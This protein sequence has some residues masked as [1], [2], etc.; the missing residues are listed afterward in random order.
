MSLPKGG[1]AIKGIGEKFAAHPVTGAGA[2]TVPV[3]ATPGRSGFGPDPVLRYGSGEGNGP[4]GL[5]WSLGLPAI[6]RRTDKGVPRYDDASDSDVFILSGAEDLVPVLVREGDGWVPEALP[7][8]AIGGARYTV[9]R[10]RPRSEGLFARIE[11]WTNTGDPADVFWRSISRDD[12]TTWYGCTPES[13][14]TDPADASRVFAWLICESHDDRGNLIAYGYKAEDD[15]GVDTAAGHERNRQRTANRHL[16]RIRY[17]NRTPWP[18]SLDAAT[19]RRPLPGDGQWHFELVLDY[20]EHDRAAPTPHGAGAWSAR[21]DAFSTFRPGFEVRT[22]RLCRRVLMFHHFPD[23][24]EVGADALVRSTELG[25][26][27]G[28]HATLTAVTHRGHQRDGGGHRTRALPPV[29]FE[30]SRPVVYHTVRELDEESLDG[31]PTGLDGTRHQ[32]VDLDGEGLP[33][34]L[35]EQGGGWFHKRNLSPLTPAR[36][37][38]GPVEAVPS[39]PSPALATGARFLDLAGDGSPDLVRFTGPDPGFQERAADGT[40]EPY[41]PFVS[42]PDRD[43]ADPNLR[44]VDLDGDGLADVLVTEDDALVWHPSL[45][46]D[47]FG[48]ERREVRARDEERGPRLVFADAEQSVVLADMTGDGLTDLVRIRNGE[49]C[50]WPNLGH[51]RFGPKI[52]MAGAP[53]DHPDR[54]D[55]RRVLL[56]D[57][58][59]SGTTDLVHLHA[60]GARIHFNRSGNDF[61]PPVALPTLPPADSIT[62]VLALDLLGNGTACLVWSSPLPADGR[63]PLRYLDLMGGVKPHLLTR[64]RNNLGA[65]TEIGYAPSTA[66]C[67]RDRRAG[68]PWETKLPFPVHVVERTTVRDKWRGT[69]FTSRHSYHHGCFDGAEREFRGFARVERTDVEDY[70]TFTAAN[71]DS[72]YV[73]ADHRLHQPPV[74]TVTWH[75]TGVPVA[76]RDPQ[77][78]FRHEYFRASEEY[79]PPGPGLDALPLGPGERREAVRAFHGALLREETYEL[80]LGAATDGE[81]PAVPVRVL[82]ATTHAPHIRLVQP[83]AGRQHAVFHTFEGESVAHHYELDLRTP[84]STPPAAPDPRIV[85]TLNLTVDP[86]GNVLQSVTVGYPRTRPS[87]LADPLLPPG[88]DTLVASVQGELRA[89]YTEI[90]TTDPLPPDPD[91]YRLPLPCETRTHELTGTGPD[92]AGDGRWVTAE[93]MLRFRLGER[94]QTGGTPVAELEH[95]RLPDGT[96]P[97]KRLLGLVRTLYYDETL[98]APLPLGGLTA[99]A[100]PYGTYALARTDAL[101]TAVLGDRATPEVRA[102]AADRT[103]SGHLGGQAAVRLLGEDA[104]GRYWRCSEGAEYDPDAPQR[105]FLPAR[106]TDAFGSTTLLE[107]DPYGLSLKAS[108]DPLGNRSEVLA[109]DY[110]VMAPRRTRDVNGNQAEVLFDALGLPAAAARSGKDGAGDHR[111]GHDTAALNPQAARRHGLVLTDDHDPVRARAL[112]LG[113]GNRWLFHFG[114]ELRDGEVVWAL[115]PPC[116]A[117][118][119][120]ER[121]ADEQPESP[122]QAAFLYAD[123]LGNTLVKKVQAEPEEPGGPLRWV[124][125]G[126]TVVNNKGNPVK[127]YEPYFSPPGSGHRFEEPGEQGVTP[128]HFYDAIGRLIRTDLPD[129]SHHRVE[130]SPWHVTDHDANDTVLEPGNGWY[131]RMSTSALP[132]ERRAARQ[133]AAHAGTPGCALLDSRGHTVVTI[134]HNRDDGVDEKHV[135]FTRRDVEGT[136]LWIQ[137]PRG[138]RVLQH[139]VPPLPPGV[140]PLDDPQNLFPHGFSP[141]YDL[142]GHALFEH[143]PDA[144]DRLTLRDAADGLLFSWNGRGFRTRT[145][146]DALRRPVG[147]YVT[148]A[149]DTNLS[150]APRDPGAPPDPEVLVEYRVHGEAHPEPDR[151]LRGRTFRV[152]DGCGVTT[153]ERYDFQGNLLATSRR[154]ARDHTGTPDWSALASLT[155]PDLIAG[156]AEALL[157]PGPALTTSTAYDA[158]DRPVATTAPDGSETRWA[159]NEAGLPERVEVRLRG[160]A[161]PTAFVT[162]VDYDA[163][164]RRT[165]VVHGNGARTA[166]TYDPATFR[167][168]GVRTTRPAGPDTTAS[169]LFANASVVQDLH[170]TH[171]PVGNVTRVEDASLATI[172]GAATARDFTHDALYRLVAA[173]GREH[174][175]QTAF[176]PDPPDAGRRDHP[177]AGA[178]VHPNDLQGLRGYVER[179]RYDAVG[180]LMHVAH[181]EGADVEAPGPVLWRR[182]HQYALDG[183]RLLATSLPGETGGLPDYAADGGYGARYGHDVHGNMTRMPHLPLMRWDHGDRLAATARQVVNDGTPETTYYVHDSAGE[184]VRKVT[185]TMGGAVKNERRYLGGFE[186]Y[187]EYG[188]G[189]TTLERETLHIGDAG[190]QIALVET[191]VLPAGRPAVRYRFT[192]HQESVCVEL[193][194]NGALVGHE[195]YHPYGTTAFQAGRTAAETGL[196]RYRYT[197]KERDDETGLSYHGARYYAPWLGRW[198]SCDPAGL[199]DGPCRYAYARCGPVRFRDPDGRF[200]DEGGKYA[201]AAAA[202]A[203]APPGE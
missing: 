103:V 165:R 5:G 155:G 176:L 126:K 86:Y 177:F 9:R 87:P 146:Y 36:A 32:W 197:G 132:A 179:F 19:G 69:A 168:T 11:R 189:G 203:G 24:P 154:F 75:H 200:A 107:H 125:D 196:K 172:A 59:G 156:A 65:E 40:W 134:A 57:V 131:A 41:T 112:L 26:A 193:D 140:H 181:H 66:F 166:Y 47:G 152:Y 117:V 72:P 118:L 28:V 49:V 63:R 187:R 25:Y 20:G 43:W 74:R 80:D 55:Q 81:R 90:R 113:A 31:L 85:H 105:F 16:K 144:G 121:H 76:G 186:L 128:L 92:V 17:G 94:Y 12:V 3:A 120:R 13:R 54:F 52:V 147:T 104:A 88:T 70:G 50:Y 8:R 34:I 98:A 136:P 143:S 27:Y 199:A 153:C 160:A 180:N 15:E 29:E 184:R 96:A 7:P 161:T 138:N 148:A 62:D 33:G 173:S 178:R 53:S 158:L 68:T 185:V 183:N 130:F 109:H 142:T 67:L 71:A 110:R 89:V 133:A 164:G 99:R 44:F 73:T 35:T 170:Y 192:D 14:I 79:A 182:H 139:V 190:E 149:G 39:R 115:H 56:A 78:P 91:R 106:W 195:E 162:G 188:A 46:E 137:D 129:G 127:Q 122:L 201:A 6:T 100:L 45:G 48:P 157:E 194:E 2:M 151:N 37:R 93:G 61:A 30:Y 1:G 97:H 191:A 124:A 202:G 114:E 169:M 83:R 21:P 77:H 116:T 38:F 42:L 123:G 101:L 64:V 198:A 145:T 171:D 167:L 163:H 4:F 175:G 141:G 102:A 119:T 51:G 18:S 10:Y 150:G 58:D 84:Q 108:T 82:T 174:A 111:T 159:Y 22:H 95:H 23:E 60:D 135:T